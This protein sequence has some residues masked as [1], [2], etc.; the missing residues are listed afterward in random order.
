MKKLFA[1]VVLALVV[2]TSAYAGNFKSYYDYATGLNTGLQISFSTQMIANY[3]RSN[4]TYKSLI[5]RFGHMFGHYGWF[6]N[7]EERYAF[8]VNEL[9]KFQALLDTNNQKV[10]LVNTE[11]KNTNGVVVQ[12]GTTTIT[13]ETGA[14]NVDCDVVIDTVEYD[15]ETLDNDGGDTRG[16]SLGQ[17]F[18]ENL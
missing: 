2:S 11:Y 13:S 9:T 17:E 18:Y 6:Q 12:R 15:G 1:S 5:D 10:T 7:M 14:T 3:E 16:K 4:K 8:Q